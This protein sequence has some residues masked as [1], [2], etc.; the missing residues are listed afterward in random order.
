LIS[1]TTF[2]QV[3]SRGKSRVGVRGVDLS[4]NDRF[5]IGHDYEALENFRHPF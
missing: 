1:V 5:R 2:G 4:V 3:T